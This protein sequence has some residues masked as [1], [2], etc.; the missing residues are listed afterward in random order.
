M[1]VIVLDG[2]F[3]VRAVRLQ[4]HGDGAANMLYLARM[5]PGATTSLS[6]PTAQVPVT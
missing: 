6:N 2:V 3:E 4:R 5:S 1:K